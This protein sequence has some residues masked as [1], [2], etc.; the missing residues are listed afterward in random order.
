MR[1]LVLAGGFPQIAL[2]EKLKKRGIFTI[3]ADYFEAPIAKNIADKFYQVSTLDVDG[4]KNLAVAEKADFLITVCTDQALLTVA[5]VSE[6]L[7]LPTYI[8]YDTAL[9][10]TNKSYMKE[11]FIKNGIPTAN[12]RIIDDVVSLGNLN[13]KFPLVVKPVDCNSSKGVIKA[14]TVDALG[15]AVKDARMMSRTSSAIVEEYLSGKEVSVDV[16]VEEGIA[17]VLDITESIKMNDNEKFVITGSLHPALISTDARRKIRLIAQ[18]IAE[19]FHLDNSPMLFQA[20]VNQDDVFILEFSA[21]TGG[22]TK[23]LSIQRQTGIDMIDAVIDLTIKKA[24]H[25]SYGKQKYPNM[26]DWYI[27]CYEGI[28]DHLE[29]FDEL[30]HEGFLLDYYL[31]KNQGAKF[32]KIRNSGD[33]LAGFTLVSDGN[34]DLIAKKDI[35]LSRIHAYSVNGEDIIY[36]N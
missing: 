19:A 17:H 24:P 18:Q 32:G 33:R 26:L 6:E 30:L 13:L 34:S 28:F 11:V 10:V 12:F 31:Y 22:G 5:K 35:A 36:R 15:K 23:Y 25:Y 4:I 20:I 2:I 3:L 8:D 1:A 21:R 27:Y 16:Y 9:E 14:L 7:G 29:G